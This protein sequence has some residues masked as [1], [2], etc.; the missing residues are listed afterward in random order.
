MDTLSKCLQQHWVHSHEEDTQDTLVYRPSDFQFP[1]S[2]GRLG[3][4]FLPVGAFVYFPIAPQDGS[5]RFTGRWTVVSPTKVDIVLDN[6]VMPP[7]S[8]NI[9]SCSADTLS[10]HK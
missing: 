1:P 5:D 7:F 4:E 6:D 2:R 10:V 3:F 9:V 8:L